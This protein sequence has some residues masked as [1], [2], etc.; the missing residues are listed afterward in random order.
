MRKGQ[1]AKAT[2]PF[3]NH[4]GI[5]VRPMIQT[6]LAAPRAGSPCHGVSFFIGWCWCWS[7]FFVLRARSQAEST[8]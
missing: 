1:A 4:R 3:E 5:G 8:R 7:S 2:W 6:G